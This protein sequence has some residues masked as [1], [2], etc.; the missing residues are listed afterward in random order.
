M[1]SVIITNY[2]YG[3]YIG[4]AIDSVLG[5]TYK[6]VELIIIDDG[7]TD[8]SDTVIKKY[9]KKTPKITYVKQ[10]NLGANATR[11]KGIDMARGRY[12]FF[13]DADNWLNDNHIELMY[14]KMIDTDADVVYSD[15]QHF[16]GDDELLQVPEFDLDTLKVTNFIDTSAL[17]DKQS[18]GENRFDLELNRKSSQDWDFFLGMALKGARV[19]KAPEQVRL[20]YRVHEKQHGNNFKSVAK[21]DQSIEVY[22]YITDKYSEKY[23]EEFSKQIRWTNNL[24]VEY[25]WVRRVALE[26]SEEFNNRIEEMGGLLSA[27]LNSKSYKIGRYITQP[28]RKA[29][30][31]IAIKKKND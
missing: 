29:S 22:R 14:Q 27:A 11:N 7:S 10:E 17:I 21:I 16:G 13:L 8:N 31:L 18:I 19:V 9:T 5:Q 1:I 3:N 15:L 24:V 12:I 20:N 30:K 25:A 2:N 26:E 4:Q 28:Y 23:P 6:D